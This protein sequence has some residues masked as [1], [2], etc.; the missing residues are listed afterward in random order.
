MPKAAVSK[1]SETITDSFI[2]I[3]CERLRANKPINR[4]MPSWGRLHVD[5]QLPFLFV[6]RRPN[7]NND[8]GAER[9]IVGEASYLLASGEGS[10]RRSLSR[11]VLEAARAMQ[12]SFGSFLVIEVWT[13]AAAE[14]DPRSLDPVAPPAFRVFHSGSF[15]LAAT[16]E[17]FADA[18]QRIR[19]RRHRASVETVVSKRIAPVSLTPVISS[20]EA[21]KSNIHVL[22][23]EV[24]PIFR[25]PA[26]RVFPVVLRNLHR[27]LS[28]SLKRGVF[29]FARSLTTHQPPHYHSLGR[30]A[31]VKAAWEVDRRLAELSSRFD[32]LLLVTP[33]NARAA[34]NTF[35]NRH[36]EKTPRFLYRPLPVTP[37]LE[38]RELYSIPLERVDDPE[39]AW[40]FRQKQYEIGRQLTALMDRGTSRFVYAN[41]Q[42]AGRPD[43]DLVRLARTLLLRIPS[44]S[45][46]GSGRDLVDAEAFRRRAN[47][48]LKFFKQTL[49]EA[50]SRVEI[51]SDISGLMVSR[52]NLLIPSD[53]KVPAS[54]L[55][56]LIQHEVGTHVLTYLNGKA[57]PLHQLYAGLSGYD[58][59][60]EGI[61][62]LSEYLVGGLSAP[63]LRLLAARV[64]AVHLMLG[65]ATFIETF[66]ELASEYD[67]A[68]QTAFTVTMRVF[69]GGGLTKDAVYLRGLVRLIKYL[70]G[71]GKFEPLL[72]GK[73]GAEHVA[74]VQELLRRQ[75]L[76]PPPI[77]PRYLDDPAAQERLVMISKQ[78]TVLDLLDR[79]R[80]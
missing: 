75:V 8:K 30:R 79:R 44:R 74:I 80:K 45:R 49:P 67:F 68:R 27:G 16:V 59:L 48:E 4:R 71:G 56:A 26:G 73:I 36:F 39:L 40:L 12:E 2:E 24:S 6:Y 1:R 77:K 14:R 32:F 21:A 33:V 22:G 63:R 53:L 61:A 54:R 58:E 25:D 50:S 66:R 72:I 13:A 35:E 70:Q 51:R 43:D 42:A 18:L 52:G 5:R 41:L 57:Q 28:N 19:I 65:G 23:L 46:E 37:G 47:S 34:W 17:G 55:E 64:I 9:L 11:L 38:K 60:Q 7:G 78:G 29:S 3:V 15:E 31:L 20:T 69:R 76:R 10:H 62:V